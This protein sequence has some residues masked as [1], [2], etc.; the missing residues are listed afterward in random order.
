MRS[1]SRSTSCSKSRS[2]SRGLPRTS[3]RVANTSSVSVATR[4]AMPR[5]STSTW[6]AG[7][8]PTSCIA[9]S[10]SA[11]QADGAALREQLLAVDA[12]LQR[13]DASV[14]EGRPQVDEDALEEEVD[15]LR[16]QMVEQAFVVADQRDC[17]EHVA[18]LVCDSADP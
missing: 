5:T 4:R 16:E 13:R 15:Q 11:D 6:F 8:V 9:R 10:G 7:P 1:I 3:G 14:D 18:R 17:A 2:V 12:V